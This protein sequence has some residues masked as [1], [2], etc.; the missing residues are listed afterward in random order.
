[1]SSNGNVKKY[2]NTKD[3]LTEEQQDVL[4]SKVNKIER[5]QSG[6]E[7]HFEPNIQK[8]SA[9]L[10]N[11]NFF[12]DINNLSKPLLQ[13][14]PM[15]SWSKHVTPNTL[16]VFQDEK[17]WNG[18]SNVEIKKSQ[19]KEFR[20]ATGLAWST[21]RDS[22]QIESEDDSE[23]GS[24]VTTQLDAKDMEIFGAMPMRDDIV[25]VKCNHCQRP[26]LASKFKEHSVSCLGSAYADGKLNQRDFF[27]DDE[28]I[29]SKRNSKKKKKSMNLDDDL[30]SLS[31]AAKRPPSASLEKNEKKKAK[32]EKMKKTTKQ[33]VAPLDLDKQCGVI[34][35][36]NNMPCTRSL[37]CKSHS[38]GAKRAVDGR[39]QPYDVLLAAYQ[40]KS[41]G[42]PNATTSQTTS[43]SSLVNNLSNGVSGKSIK[44]L[45]RLQNQISST[46]VNGNNSLNSGVNNSGTSITPT[47]QTNE[48]TYVD[49]DEEVENVMQALR[50]SRPAPLAQKPFFFVKRRRQC[51]RLRDILLDAM[52]P[53]STVIKDTSSSISHSVL[54]NNAVMRQSYFQQQQQQQQQHQHQQQHQQQHSLG[55]GFATNGNN[56]M[57]VDN[58]GIFGEPNSPSFS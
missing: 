18:I 9:E 29:E 16:S 50:L 51:Y 58:S 17:S 1:M 48:E 33:K 35:G 39:S 19:G 5:L 26:L 57:V 2:T 45:K 8:R 53:K 10:N 6:K 22:M 37:T 56:S 44:N 54:D 13:S 11:S 55:L 40:K 31:T 12:V 20:D 15:A 46:S 25:V 36:L 23:S 21:L 32:K 28:E 49:S 24:P 38:M 52:T 43:G 7:R 3:L 14:D 34:Q 41:I 27:S 4:R 47:T 42:R 30:D